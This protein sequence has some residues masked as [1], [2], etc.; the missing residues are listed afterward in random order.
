MGDEALPGISLI[1]A[2]FFLLVWAVRN[3]WYNRLENKTKAKK[4]SKKKPTTSTSS[5]ISHQKSKADQRNI[6]V[7]TSTLEEKKKTELFKH[8]K[9]N[10]V[11]ESITDEPIVHIVQPDQKP[12][13]RKHKIFVSYRRADSADVTGRICDRL[14]AQFGREA[15][16]TDVD[17]I[18]LGVNFRTHIEQIVASCDVFIAVI[19]RDWIGKKAQES[20]TRRIDD[21]RDFVRIEVES[22]LKRDIPIIPTL[23]RGAEIPNIHSLP[24]AIQELAYRNGIS[25]RPDPDFHRDMD[26]FIS[27][28][29]L[30]MD[31]RGIKQKG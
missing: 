17:S 28:L 21:P 31:K 12:A 10:E 27:G 2:V 15:V 25:V 26:R 6:N 9:S 29:N 11:L 18:P 13:T 7:P 5:Q 1:L 22:A 8:N 20:E 30:L 16:F 23:V 24:E 4:V 19:G 3:N 14:A